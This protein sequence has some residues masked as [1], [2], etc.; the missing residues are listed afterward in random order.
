MS[1]KSLKDLTI[2]PA[3]P[4]DAGSIS[5][6]HELAF[7]Q[8]GEAQLIESLNDEAAVVLSLLAEQDG[9]LLGHLLFS[10]LQSLPEIG[11]VVSLAPIAVM[12]DTQRQGIGSKLIQAAHQQ[13][14]AS[15]EVLSVVLGEP[16]YYSRFGYSLEL[17]A[18]IKCAYSG[19]YLMVLEL[20][21]GV[22]NELE[23]IEI[24]Y[25]QAFSGL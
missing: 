7:G 24:T 6:I 12:P 19:P 20:Q 13:L 23:S 21:P 16:A 25:P 11:P 14:Q 4:G 1:L 9:A 5:R 2:R 8:P 15:G 3:Q 10:R 22:L 17:G 18:K